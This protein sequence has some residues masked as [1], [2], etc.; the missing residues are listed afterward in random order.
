[1]YGVLGISKQAHHRARQ[2]GETM[3]ELGGIIMEECN[4]MRQ[5]HKAIGCVKIHGRIGKSIGLGRDRFLDQCRSLGL[6]VRRKRSP[7]R[8]THSSKE[9]RFT[10]L[11]DGLVLTGP[12]QLWQSDIFYIHD[13]D[14]HRYGFTIIDVYT[15]E[16]LA[17]QYATNMRADNLEKAIKKAVKRRAGENLSGCVFHSDGGKQYEDLSV[18]SYLKSKG[19]KQSMC[20]R[21]QQNAYAERVQG[22]LKYEYLFLDDSHRCMKQKFNRAMQ[23]YNNSRPHDELGGLTPTEF[24]QRTN[25]TPI[26]ERSEMQVY[27]WIE[28]ILTFPVEINKRKKY[29]KRKQQQLHL[30]NN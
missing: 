22:T 23:L 4:K 16:L 3:I 1:L 12:N 18:M 28:P 13:M 6:F 27:Q 17:L 26:N 21:A 19:M 29:Q 7:H 9:R 2:R 25:N 20:I 14:K 8:T 30:I 11:S 5:H 10:N 15:R 24:Q